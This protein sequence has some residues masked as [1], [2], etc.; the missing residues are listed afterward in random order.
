MRDVGRLA[1]SAG[2][3]N[4]CH[5]TGYINPESLKELAPLLGAA[6]I[7]LKAFDG[8]FY[9]DLVDAKL[10]PVLN[11]LKT[12]RRHKV[13]VE[14]VNLVIPQYERA[15]HPLHFLPISLDRSLHR[16]E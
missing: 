5:S 10:L 9:R 15:R 16:C 7:D 1:K 8:K 13:H 14:K 3:L 4:T 12:L 11:T 6:C 2:I